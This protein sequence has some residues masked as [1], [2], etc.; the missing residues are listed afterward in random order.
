MIFIENGGSFVRI[1]KR[2]GLDCVLPKPMTYGSI[3]WSTFGRPVRGFNRRSDNSPLIKIAESNGSP[4]KR[5]YAFDSA[6]LLCYAVRDAI[7]TG[8]PGARAKPGPD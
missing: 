3:T 7:R 6:A 8:V 5:S 4:D 1:A 2:R